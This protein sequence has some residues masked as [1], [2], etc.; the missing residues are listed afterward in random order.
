MC[1]KICSNC[2]N[3]NCRCE[4]CVCLVEQNE[5]WYCDEYGKLCAEIIDCKEGEC[6]E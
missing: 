2:E 4:S 6:A 1:S 5:Q 3:T